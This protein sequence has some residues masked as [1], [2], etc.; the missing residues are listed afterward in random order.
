MAKDTGDPLEPV[1]RQAMRQWHVV[2]RRQR[3]HIEEALKA[4]EELAALERVINMQKA[5]PA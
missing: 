5:A 4:K 3:K 1:L 2:E